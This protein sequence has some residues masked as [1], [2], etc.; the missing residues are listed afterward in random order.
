MCY[1]E[2]NEGE[3]RESTGEW[4][5]ENV[6]SSVCHVKDIFNEYISIRTAAAVTTLFCNFYTFILLSFLFPPSYNTKLP[7]I[8]S[9]QMTMMEWHSFFFV[10]YWWCLS[11]RTL[12][13]FF[14]MK[15]KALRCAL[16]FT[17]LNNILFTFKAT[18]WCNA[19]IFY[20]S[21]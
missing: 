19:E 16:R 1:T 14:S 21:V 17:Y 5:R 11:E 10:Q 7:I 4:E 8:L 2:R 3:E 6:A 15:Q 20:K 12:L 18:P 13:Y 9:S